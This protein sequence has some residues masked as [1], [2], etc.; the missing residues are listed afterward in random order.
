MSRKSGDDRLSKALRALS[1]R[2]PIW[3]YP[4]QGPISSALPPAPSAPTLWLLG[5]GRGGAEESFDVECLKWQARLRFSLS[6]RSSVVWRYWQDPEAGLGGQLPCLHLPDGQLLPPALI[7][8]WI[9]EQRGDVPKQKKKAPKQTESAVLAELER[10]R[11]EQE[12]AQEKQDTKPDDGLTDEQ[13]SKLNDLLPQIDTSLRLYIMTQL[14]LTPIFTTYTTPLYHPRAHPSSPTLT[15]MLHRML[16]S[17]HKSEAI[18]EI[19]RLQARVLHGEAGKDE[20]EVETD[21]AANGAKW[22]LPFKLDTIIRQIGQSTG[23]G[24]ADTRIDLEAIEQQALT[25]LATLDEQ[26][27]T[28]GASKWLLS[29]QDATEVDATLFAML[30]TLQTVS[31]SSQASKREN[32]VA[33]F[34]SLQKWHGD[35]AAEYFG[36]RVDVPKLDRQS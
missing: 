23:V 2:F 6:E 30:H 16:A 25:L 4:A 22:Y 27:S 15:R 34:S 21:A 7:P 12:K 13:R 36:D 1:D 31:K 9:H 32:I 24:P 8:D 20:K 33:R 14:Y 17:S 11:A 19:Q 26:V 5:P 3:L 10:K 29:T 28:L 18:A 35:R